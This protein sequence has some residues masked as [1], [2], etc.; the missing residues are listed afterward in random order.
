MV[1]PC[2]STVSLKFTDPVPGSGAHE[3]RASGNAQKA[4][5]ARTNVCIRYAED[6]EIMSAD[7]K[8]SYVGGVSKASGQLCDHSLCMVVKLGPF[9]RH[10]YEAAVAKKK[11]FVIKEKIGHNGLPIKY[12]ELQMWNVEW[13]LF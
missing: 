9:A 3:A 10:L 8:C 2:C 6:V 4:C 11:G 7:V 13:S 12:V 1:T 5:T